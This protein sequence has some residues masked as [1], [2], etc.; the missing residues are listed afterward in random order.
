MTWRR[1]GPGLLTFLAGLV[2]GCVPGFIISPDASFLLGAAPPAEQGPF[3]SPERPQQSPAPSVSETFEM[4]ELLQ[5]QG[6]SRWDGQPNSPHF[7]GWVRQASALQGIPNAWVATGD[8]RWATTDASGRFS[9]PG[10]PPPNGV[11]SAGAPG[12]ITS[13]I[14]GLRPDENLVF[15]LEPLVSRT[16]LKATPTEPVP[17][18]LSGRVVTPQ[19]GPAPGV[20]VILG[21]EQVQR[22]VVAYTDAQGAFRIQP[23]L[24]R[25]GG[26]TATL[27]AHGSTG[28][29]V[30]MNVP[31][32]GTGQ[33]I[34][35]VRLQAF[36]HA[37]TVDV[38][39]A[40]DMPTPV[41]VLRLQTPDGTSLSLT[42]SGPHRLAE[43]PQ[44]TFALRISST[45][46]D[47]GKHS[48]ISRPRVSVDWSTAETRL[49]EQMLAPPEVQEIETLDQ[50]VRLNWEP[51]SGA[52]GYTLSINSVE[53]VAGLPWE[54][55]AP[56]P[57][58]F[59]ILPRSDFPP[60]FYRLNVT[61]W[62][63]PNLSM[64]S[65]AQFEPRRLKR[66]PTADGF[67]KAERRIS[68]KI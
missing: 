30:R 3:P 59:F 28:Q 25:P 1:T 42:G 5:R 45:T 26:A 52:R 24:R 63:V 38:A 50:D 17:V 4:V 48:E 60:G 13:A 22:N 47:G 9:L 14:S 58:T 12:H 43:E 46:S 2:T 23:R 10:Q 8:G 65:L 31:L 68:L 35:T 41:P 15:H 55:F 7:S 20:L 67:R 18:T 6:G 33:T 57:P 51:V 62:D 44:L 53:R 27:L 66:V 40:P 49:V 32:T 16:P 54:A 61:A 36:S 34:D 56:T 29:A 37:V 21:G 11:Y 19:G 39:G 64:R